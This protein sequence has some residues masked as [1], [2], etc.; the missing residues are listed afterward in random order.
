MAVDFTGSKSEMAVEQ[1]E[2]TYQRF[3]TWTKISIV[4]LVILMGGMF[5]FLV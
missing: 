3:M 5:L 1:H 4:F 2:E